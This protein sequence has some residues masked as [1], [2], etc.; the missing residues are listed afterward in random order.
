[1]TAAPTM[2]TA[3]SETPSDETPSIGTGCASTNVAARRRANRPPMTDS[4]GDESPKDQA[5]APARASPEIETGASRGKSRVVSFDTSPP[6]S[7][8]PAA[9]SMART[10]RSFT[11]FTGSPLP[12]PALAIG[13]ERGQKSRHDG[14]VSQFC[15]P[16]E[17]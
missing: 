7:F 4:D 9:L 5:A 12:G 17:H 1:M 3:A 14:N 6:G 11:V 10:G 16:V 15:L 2:K 8:L 13:E